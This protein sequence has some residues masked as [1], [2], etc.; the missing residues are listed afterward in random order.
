MKLAN[1]SF[2]VQG[3][4]YEDLISKAELKISDFINQS[5]DQLNKY[6]SYEIDISEIGNSSKKTYEAQVSARIKNV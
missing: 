1:F 2:N 6:V 3:E 5:V 4:S